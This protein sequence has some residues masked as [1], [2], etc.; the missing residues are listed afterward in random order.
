MR[1]NLPEEQFTEW[2][3]LEHSYTLARW[4]WCDNIRKHKQN[5]MELNDALVSMV[6]RIQ[7]FD[8][9]ANESWTERM[10]QADTA[11]EVIN[12]LDQSEP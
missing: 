8:A 9:V 1:M 11:A 12:R 6:R 2:K 4:R 7:G 10:R 5:T 3:D